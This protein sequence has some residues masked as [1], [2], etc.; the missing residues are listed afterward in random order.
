MDKSPL[1]VR[2]AGLGSSVSLCP[3]SRNKVGLM[4]RFFV[5]TGDKPADQGPRGQLCSTARQFTERME[6]FSREKGTQH[7]FLLLLVIN[8]FFRLFK[9]ENLFNSNGF[10]V[11]V[12]AQGK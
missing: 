10:G 12:M 4:H 11:P 9:E 3:L 6:Q 7:I 8:S 2:A 5:L 1:S